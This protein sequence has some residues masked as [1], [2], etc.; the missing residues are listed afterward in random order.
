MILGPNGQPYPYRGL[1]DQNGNPYGVRHVDNKPR[2]SAMPYLY[3]IAE[4]N[5]S[6][7]YEFEQLGYNGDIDITE[8]DVWPT[9]G[10]Y[11]F[12][13][14][15]AG[16]EVLSTSVEDDPDKG[17]AVPGTGIHA[18]TIHYLDGTGAKKSEDV[19]LNG[20]AVVAT[21]NTDYY[22]VLSVRAKTVGTGG[23]AAGVISVRHLAD[24][25][26]Y[27]TIEQGQTRSRLGIW[28]VPLGKTLFITSIS[29][30][31]SLAA[32]S[33][34]TF[35]LRATYDHLAAA[36]RTFFIAHAEVVCGNNGLYR[37]FELPM[38]F[39]AGTDI[40]VSART[41][42]NNTAVSVGLR[43]WYEDT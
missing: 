20:T 14:S 38:R 8:E 37:P 17:G 13:A 36:T 15:A 39:P 42:A 40:K 43:G 19:T 22:R 24:T 25:P 9:G 31:A 5:V 18:I 2:V 6:G 11:V 27:A 28:T 4:L 33:G 12:P 21:S 35:T 34:A 1:I 3:D 30:G 41:I 32:Q 29:I 10:T 23:Y 7:H 26:V 16:L